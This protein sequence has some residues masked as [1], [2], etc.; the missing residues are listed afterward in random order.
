MQPAP[1]LQS[2][3]DV[4]FENLVILRVAVGAT[5]FVATVVGFTP[6]CAVDSVEL[7]SFFHSAA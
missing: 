1:E 3:A 2:G 5:A 6:D 7:N 4:R